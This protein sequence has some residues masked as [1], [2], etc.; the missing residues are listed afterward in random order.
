MA[1]LLGLEHHDRHLALG[2]FLVGDIG[3][4]AFCHHF[5]QT[6]TH[7]TFGYHRGTVLYLVCDLEP[8]SRACLQIVE[9]GEKAL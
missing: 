1:A 6:L 7:S 4:V 5:E 9:Q 3:H 8:D 2:F